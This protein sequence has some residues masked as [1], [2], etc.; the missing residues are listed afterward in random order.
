MTAAFEIL[1]SDEH[2]KAIMVNIFGGI[3]KCDVIASGI[4]EAA[5]TIDIKVPVV[6]RLEGTNV[7]QGKKILSE[8]G[9][10]LISAVDMADAAHK[11]VMLAKEASV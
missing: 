8:S 6:V 4:D 9:L 2:V 7:E 5:K 1:L 11:C 10:D 3:M